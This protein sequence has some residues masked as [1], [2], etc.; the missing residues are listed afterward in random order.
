MKMFYSSLILV[1]EG[2]EGCPVLRFSDNLYLKK[3]IIK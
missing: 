2:F 3:G 1:C